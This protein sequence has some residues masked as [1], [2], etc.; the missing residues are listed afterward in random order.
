MRWL[1][2]ITDSKDLSLSKLGDNEGQQSLACCNPGSHKESD[3]TEQQQQRQNQKNNRYDPAIPPQGVYPQEMKTLIQ[4]IHAM[5]IATLFT[6]VKIWKQHKYPSTE[7]QRSYYIYIY[8]YIHTHIMHIYIIYVYTYTHTHTH[9]HH[10][11]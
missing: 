6:I 8:T 5:F 7:E 11:I 2:G 3:M 9:T 4:K 10:G 1:D